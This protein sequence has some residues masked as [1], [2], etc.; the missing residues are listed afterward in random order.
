MAGRKRLAKSDGSEDTVRRYLD[1]IGAYPL[2]TA[3]EEVDLAKAI[4]RG[5]KAAEALETGL[6]DQ[7]RR[8]ALALVRRGNQAR[9]QFISAN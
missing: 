4:E 5:K 9:E 2:L 7:D 8:K 3:Q 1:E 6:S